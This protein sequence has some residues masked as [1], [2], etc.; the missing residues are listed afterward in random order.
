MDDKAIVI[1]GA[2]GQV[3]RALQKVY[4]QALALDREQLDITNQKAINEFN[5]DNVKVIINAAAWTDVDG[6]E[7]PSNYNLVKAVNVDASRYLATAAS[8]HDLT[9]VTFSSDY[10]F[11]GS[12]PIHNEDELFSPL[13]I[14]G[15]T[16]A[17]GDLAAATTI[18]HYIIRTSWVIGDGRNFVNIMQDLAARG[19]RP[20][21][22]NDQIGRLTFTDTLAR[23]IRHL[24]ET[25][26]PYGTYN[27]TN[28]G[29]PASWADIAKIIVFEKSGKS[30]SDIQPV[31]TAEYFASKPGVAQRPLQSTLDLTKIEKTGFI[32]EDWRDKLDKLLG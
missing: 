28:E 23:G 27:L 31:S 1:T 11:D 26:A 29:Q 22:V 15:K 25:G 4:P 5:W 14:Y 21:V 9:F 16:K 30:S 24:L 18:K 7:N 3:G 6:A 17:D 20:S 19:V 10:V 12:Q 8:Q 2:N 32:P 13:N